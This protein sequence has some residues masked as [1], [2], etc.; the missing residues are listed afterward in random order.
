MSKLN[1]LLANYK[2]KPLNAIIGLHHFYYQ[3][4]AE[5]HV[6]VTRSIFING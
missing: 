2:A 1:S 4:V 6:Y 5:I 3:A